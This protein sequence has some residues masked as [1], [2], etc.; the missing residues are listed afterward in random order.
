[1]HK[2]Y[3]ALVIIISLLLVSCAQKPNML[4]EPETSQTDQDKIINQPRNY[5]MSNSEIADYLDY[6]YQTKSMYIAG[7][8]IFVEFGT[9]NEGNVSINTKENTMTFTI[10]KSTG[11]VTGTLEGPRVY[12][13]MDL[14]T[15]DIMEKKFSPAPNYAELA[16]TEFAEHS[17]EVIQLTDERLVEIGTYFKELIMEIEA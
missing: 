16:L 8:K 4:N 6:N 3:A 7:L 15:N 12:F 17:E 13:K 10:T 14:T 2:K 1:M 11:T 9:S 5:E